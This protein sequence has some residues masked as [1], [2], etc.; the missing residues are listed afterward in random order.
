MSS[1]GRCFLSPVGRAAF[2]QAMFVLLMMYFTS[3]SQHRNVTVAHKVH[4]FLD[5]DMLVY[6]FDTLD[7]EQTT[8]DRL[9]MSIAE[10][11]F[12][13]RCCSSPYMNHHTR[14]VIYEEQLHCIMRSCRGT[15]PHH[16]SSSSASPPQLSSKGCS[17]IFIARLITSLSPPCS[18]R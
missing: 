2:Y 11:T 6:V 15:S 18:T 17:A 1:S 14:T 9:A 7:D 3:L 5:K 4:I 16:R 8:A 12:H 13:G 10:E